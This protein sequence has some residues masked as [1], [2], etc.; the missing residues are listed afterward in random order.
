MTA[1][2][3][4]GVHPSAYA[5]PTAVIEAGAEIGAAT[6]IWHHS[7]VR[8]GGRVGAG[9]TL[10]K[11]VFVD[12]GAI[13]GDRVKIQNNVS[14]YHGVTIGN[15]VF[16]GPSAVF[17][18]DLRPRAFATDWQISPTVVELGAS[19][20]ANATVVCGVTIG[21]YAMVA[22]GSVVTRSV[23]P[24]RLVLG[25]PARPHAWVCWCGEI[26]SRDQQQP[27]ELRCASCV[28]AS[29]SYE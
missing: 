24:H 10:G 28:T 15:D 20:G 23:E 13:V 2:G 14:V 5:H 29:R 9:C 21:R 4:T 18:N 16:V 22:A 11:N 7:H 8:E 6:R 19:I 12:A 27:L 1:D 25:N 17:T 3:A 26:V